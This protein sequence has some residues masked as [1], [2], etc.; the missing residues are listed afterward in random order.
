MKSA[1]CA[2]AVLIGGA[3]FY[4]QGKPEPN[5]SEAEV[6]ASI[7]EFIAAF[8][9]GDVD[10]VMSHW[11]PNA[12]Y[13]TDEGDVYQGRDAIRKAV[14]NAFTVNKGMKIDCGE[15]SI[16]MISA[17]VALEE[18]T[19]SAKMSDGTVDFTDYVAIHVRR[20]GLT[21]H[22]TIQSRASTPKRK[23]S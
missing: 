4:V 3:A 11:A 19:C 2:V 17:D 18:G 10:G 5:Q 13:R 23:N 7:K 6:R 14:A 16:R 9:K 1:C 15:P 22:I 21:K 20:D 8:N 12:F